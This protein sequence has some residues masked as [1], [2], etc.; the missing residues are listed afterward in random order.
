MLDL[1][2]IET[3]NGG[4]L[5]LRGN[6]LVVTTGMENQPYLSQFG[7]PAADEEDWWANDLLLAE[8]PTTQFR[9][10]TEK[11]LRTVLT[12]ASRI[13][14]EQAAKGDIDFLK[15]AFPGT[16]ISCTASIV[17]DDRLEMLITINGQQFFY[18]WNPDSSFLT[19]KI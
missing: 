3:G 7:G 11:A 12:S 5:V 16:E 8:E 19:Y 9:S 4:D 13:Q 6:D 2:L 10:E 1:L 17:A 14:I 15:T 18:E